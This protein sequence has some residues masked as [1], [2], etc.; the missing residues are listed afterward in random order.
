MYYLHLFKSLGN[1]CYRDIFIEI[2]CIY[3][4]Y[5]DLLSSMKFERL[6]F[7]FIEFDLHDLITSKKYSII[8]SNCKAN[9]KLMRWFVLG[10]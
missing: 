6:N 10:L 8:D 2:I 9:L 7:A 3:E 5:I 1:A 4:Q